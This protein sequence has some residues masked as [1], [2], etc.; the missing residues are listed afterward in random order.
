MSTP[1]KMR[2]LNTSKIGQLLTVTG[3]ITRTS[4][5]RPELLLGTFR[6]NL[7]LGLYRDVLQQFQY[8]EPPQC[9]NPHCLN[10]NDWTLLPERSYFVN[11]QRIR[12]QECAEEIPSGSMP[13]CMDVIVRNEMVDRAKAGD[14]CT[15]TG[16]L[17][18]IPDITSLALP[19]NQKQKNDQMKLFW[20]NF[21]F[22]PHPHNFFFFYPNR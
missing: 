15:F 11:W 17:I 16:T 10:T 21:G 13:R 6:C 7:C 20:P 9:S 4:E 3:T 8:T 14:K 5:I 12:V 1:F 22:H 2:E 18:V 19:G